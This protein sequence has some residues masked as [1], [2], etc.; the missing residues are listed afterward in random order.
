[1]NLLS[2]TDKNIEFWLFV[3]CGLKKISKNG[4]ENFLFVL[5]NEVLGSIIIL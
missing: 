5:T 1:M 3:Y 4:G 2:N